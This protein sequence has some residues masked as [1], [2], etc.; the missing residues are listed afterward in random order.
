MRK[1]LVTGG[2]G[3]VGTALIP[4][5]ARKYPVVC[6]SANHFGNPISWVKNVEFVEGDIR[7]GAKLSQAIKGC[8]DVIHLAG[9]VT[10]ELAAMNP[11]LAKDININGMRQLCE[12]ATLAGVNRFIY[13]SSSGVYGT[14]SDGI[15]ASETTEPRPET[16]YMQTK[17]EGEKVLWSFP[18]LCGVAVRSATCCGP[19]PR[20]RL[21]TIVNIFC[22]QAFF[23]GEITVHDG[24]QWRTN[25]HVQDIVSLY[26]RLVD[27]FVR[28]IDKQIFNAT[29][30]NH[31]ATSI[32]NMVAE[33]I[34]AIVTFDISKKDRRQYLMSADKANMILRW[35]P[36]RT[37]KDAIKDNRA[38]FEGGG[39]QQP[40]SDLYYNTRRMK[41]LMTIG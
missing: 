14:Q 8:T 5:L 29:A 21:D 30:E 12:L 25:I 31:T 7:D 35:Y 9:I 26:I 19:A 18:K 2:T 39:I 17:L 34:P 3:Y 24:T 37:I 13:A 33:I 38:F 16:V 22:K 11:E 28:K 27:Y 15:P 41:E 1:I 4:R 23:D 20:M 6:Y 40:D 32:A 10:D 36:E